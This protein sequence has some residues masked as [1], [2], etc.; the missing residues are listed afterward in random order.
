[1]G[2]ILQHFQAKHYN[3]VLDHVQYYN[4][5]YTHDTSI[6]GTSKSKSEEIST[7]KTELWFSGQIYEKNSINL[8]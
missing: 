2:L 7:I 8:I 3:Y 6:H 5:L 1:M 4:I